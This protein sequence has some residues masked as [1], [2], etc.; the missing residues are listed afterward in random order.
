MSSTDP[1]NE[2]SLRDEHELADDILDELES[3]EAD[4]S[5]DDLT[6]NE[7]QNTELSPDERA[8]LNKI[9]EAERKLVDLENELRV[10]DAEIA[11][12]EE[13]RQRYD[14]LQRVFDG[15]KE[16]ERMDAGHLFWGDDDDKDALQARVAFAERS[17]KEF[18]ADL[19]ER[20]DHRDYIAAQIDEQN[21]ALDLLDTRLRDAMEE[22]ERRRAE[23]IVE[24]EARELAYREQVMPW[25]RAQEEDA[26][27]RK[28]ALGAFLASLLLG[29]LLPY[30][31]LPIP[32][33]DQL[34]EVPERVA[35]M[36]ERELPEPEPPAPEPVAEEEEI[37]EPEPE[38]ELVEEVVE[39]PEAVVAT[40]TEA[41]Q[42]T[43]QPS[44]PKGI[45]AFKESI[46]NT[47]LN[48]PG[49]R[50]G[51]QARVSS[52]GE[53]AVGR[54]ERSMVTTSA[55][56]SSGGINLSDISRSVAGGGQGIE[57]VEVATVA[58]SIGTGAG[59]DRP[60]SAGL[61]AGRTDEEIQIVFDRY[62]AALYRLYN[63]ELRRDP[64]LRGQMVL[65]LT[66]EPDGSVSMCEV[67][68]SDL[69]APNL[70]DQVVARV[71]GFDFGAK[72]DIAAVTIIYPIDFLPAG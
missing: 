36:I 66:I 56:G 30:I 43:P 10:A 55:P 49:A 62:K 47:A 69:D 72:E 40:E 28:A 3:A 39:E 16:L 4:V 61:T 45:L 37:V 18:E 58:S 68:S 53:S 59:P 51:S 44:K 20:H 11:R 70:S 60:L 6:E 35:S 71:K 9:D 19:E 67:Q 65:R 21:L 52:A 14:V 41:E 25:A 63:R 34:T 7:P 27:F 12:F 29:L 54:P 23:W 42:P 1:T 15:L 24:N 32:L 38:E 64:T 26:R 50:L 22:E 5:V 31:D 8:V 33:R 2:H 46:A 17:L 57:G 13:R 48:R